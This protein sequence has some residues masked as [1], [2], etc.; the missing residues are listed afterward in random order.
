MEL[1]KGD[2]RSY[3]AVF[4]DDIIWGSS[5]LE[6]HVEHFERILQAMIAADMV[7]SAEKTVLCQDELKFLGMTMTKDGLRPDAAK[8]AD[9]LGMP[10]PD[11]RRKLK[12][13]LGAVNYHTKF[14]AK[15]KI[16]TQP[17]WELDAELGRKRRLLK[18]Q[19]DGSKQVVVSEE[20]RKRGRLSR[21][22]R[23]RFPR[24]RPWPFH[25]QGNCSLLRRMQAT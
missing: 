25:N 14:L 16:I 7:V 21:M 5:S 8:V 6:I 19:P 2:E 17:L 3:L 4:V 13:F 11:S 15:E 1:Q 10:F 12:R 24:L 9:I 22:S 23:K 18:V 20:A